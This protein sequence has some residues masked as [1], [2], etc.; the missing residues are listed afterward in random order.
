M[1]TS[2]DLTIAALHR[3]A[4]ERTT[5]AIGFVGKSV[6]IEE[7]SEAAPVWPAGLLPFDLVERGA[8]GRLDAVPRGAHAQLLPLSTVS[9]AVCMW[10]CSL[11]NRFVA[12]VLRCVDL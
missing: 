1:A 10:V 4:A 2:V 12:A 7:S 5:G 11:S 8:S 3:Q 6:L 9:P